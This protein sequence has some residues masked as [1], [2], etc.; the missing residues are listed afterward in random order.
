MLLEMSLG[1][2]EVITR[3]YR[4]IVIVSPYVVPSCDLIARP[5]LIKNFDGKVQKLEKNFPI[6]GQLTLI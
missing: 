4:P 5:P 6:S 2:S 3:A 1:K